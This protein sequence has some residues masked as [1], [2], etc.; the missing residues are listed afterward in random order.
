MDI[1]LGEE[2]YSAKANQLPVRPYEAI[3]KTMALKEGTDTGESNSSFFLFDR[4][5]WKTQ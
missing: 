5:P 2:V 3:L 4:K 1:F